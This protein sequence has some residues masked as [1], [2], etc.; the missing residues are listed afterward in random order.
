VDIFFASDQIDPV[1][2]SNVV[3]G[4]QEKAVNT[5]LHQVFLDVT[6]NYKGKSLQGVL[7]FSDGAD[8][9]QDPSGI[10]PE[11]TETLTRLNGP[12]H[13]FQAGSNEG[14][15]DLAIEKVDATDFGFVHQPLNIVVTV[16]ARAIGKKNIPLVLKEGDKILVS[17]IVSL[18]AEDSQYTAELHFT[19]VS[20][21]KRIYTLS[22]PVFAGEAVEVNN[23]WSFEVKV[24]RDRVRVLHLN[25][26]P[27]WDSRFLRETLA[28][29]PKVDLLSFFILR[30]LTDDV[31]AT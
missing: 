12:V 27:S 6:E 26:R 16:S 31:G 8:L 15:K 20:L 29:N 2:L 24:I 3:T 28:N 17:K 30:T 21:G 7:L 25:G 11:F 10:S 23:R 5:D 19:P 4:Y 14:F 13:T 9:T 1:P 22:V 18:K